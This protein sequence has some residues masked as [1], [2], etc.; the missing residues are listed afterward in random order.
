MRSYKL[1]NTLRASDNVISEV[2]TNRYIGAVVKGF[3]TFVYCTRN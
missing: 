2:N 3:A 1:G